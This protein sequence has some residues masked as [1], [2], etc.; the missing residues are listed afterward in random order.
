MGNLE[1]GTA[2]TVAHSK[3][4]RRKI[5]IIIGLSLSDW[6]RYS[7]RLDCP[8]PDLDLLTDLRNICTI[9]IV[10]LT[11]SSDASFNFRLQDKQAQHHLLLQLL[12]HCGWHIH[13]TPPPQP[14]RYA[15]PAHS[16]SPLVYVPALPTAPPHIPPVA[17]APV[18]PTRSTS[19]S[20]S[21]LSH[22][23]HI[24][25]ITHSCTIPTNLQTFLDI[26][27]VPPAATHRLLTALSVQIV[28]STHG[29]VRLRRRLEK[30]PHT[31]IPPLPTP[32]LSHRS[33]TPHPAV[34]PALHPFHDPP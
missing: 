13:S 1:S 24:F 14:R 29:L 8:H 20:T 5:H 7:S 16:S 34:S 31:F 30:D 22:H 27:Q 4:D 3:I 21:S 26:M 10:E 23:V 28:R 19:S 12:L 25:I 9:H 6:A 2:S 15:L 17:L 32:P 33:T 11:F 18:R